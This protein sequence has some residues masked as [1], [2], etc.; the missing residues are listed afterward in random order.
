MQTLIESWSRLQLSQD[1]MKTFLLP[2]PPV[3]EQTRIVAEVGK[4]FSFIS[5]LKC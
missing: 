5:L 2:L 3:K 1:K 4:L